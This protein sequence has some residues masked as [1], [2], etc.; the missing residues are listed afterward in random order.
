MDK[1]INDII[2][3]CVFWYSSRVQRV[4]ENSRGLDLSGTESYEIKGCYDCGGLEEKTCYVDPEIID[5]TQKA[6]DKIRI[7]K[8]SEYKK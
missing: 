6:M 1:A 2:E 8:N 4:E 5:I 3:K 7:Y